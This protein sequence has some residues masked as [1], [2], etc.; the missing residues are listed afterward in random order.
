MVVD[1]LITV[2]NFKY[3]YSDLLLLIT[4]IY[5]TYSALLLVR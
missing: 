2:F 1:V 4:V 3:R 5:S